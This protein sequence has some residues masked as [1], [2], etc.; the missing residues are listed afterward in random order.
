MK[1]LVLAFLAVA[2]MTA[3]ISCAGSASSSGSGDEGDRAVFALVNI[4]FEK[5]YEAETDGDYDAYSSATQ[6]AANGAMCYGT[7]HKTKGED[8]A[9]KTAREAEPSATFT[10]SEEVTA[11]ITYPV[12]ID[13]ATLRSLGGKEV[14]DSSP[15]TDVTITG[16]GAS[17]IRYEGKQNLYH[18]GDYAY[19]ILSQAPVAYKEAK[20]SRGNVSFG[21]IK[22]N[23]KAIDTLFVT[24]EPGEAHHNFS[25]AITL[26]V[27][28]ESVSSAEGVGVKK[29]TFAELSDKAKKVTAGADGSESLSEQNLSALKTIIA[30]STDGKSYGLTVLNNMFW[31]K[32]QIGFQAPGDDL[33]PQHELVGKQIAKLSF[34]TEKEVYVAENIIT[35]TVSG[36]VFTPA[37]YE[38]GESAKIRKA[39]ASSSSVADPSV[40]VVPNLKATDD[41]N[42]RAQ[43]TSSLKK[44]SK[45]D[46][47][48]AGQNGTYD[49]LFA[50][51]NRSEY[52][53]AWEGA[54]KKYIED[55]KTVKT[56]AELFKGSCAGTIY[57]E[58]AIRVYT[59][60]PES[61]KFDCF[62]TNGVSKLVF[63]GSRISGLSKSGKKVFDH[64][65]YDIGTFVMPTPDGD[66]EGELYVTLDGGAGE[67][68]YFFMMGDTPDSTYHI[69]FRYGSKTENLSLFAQGP[70][71]YWLAAGIPT[72]ASA[73]TVRKCIEL[74]V[75]ENLGSMGQVE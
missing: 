3:F 57:G 31:G 22:G 36:N 46:F 20:G 23:T 72:D 2:T 44:L 26:Y 71:A 24:V 8:T 45:A 74:F 17:T 60:A 39:V 40:F 67:F 25:P 69:E 70:Y 5:F 34:V 43:F 55:E 42:E 61:A 1:K 50:V 68:K 41:K 19:Y 13:L 58:E 65:Y 47:K 51:T 37:V 14:S 11:G 54:V 62:F 75:D 29:L 33:L 15:S 35:G 21:K 66:M 7:Y 10:P 48:K 4:P 9:S 16:R 63:D 49:E 53:S 28:D 32:S 52:N 6:K 73:D 64:E 27:K 59:A 18:S 30:T 56:Y 12:K 38:A